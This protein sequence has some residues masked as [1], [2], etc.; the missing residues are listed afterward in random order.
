MTRKEPQD[1]L[2]QARG[3]PS[4]LYRPPKPGPCDDLAAFTRNIPLDDGRLALPAEL[5]DALRLWSLSRPQEGFTSRPELRGHVR[6]GLL[7]A[8]RLA[9]RLGPSWPVRFWDERHRTAKWVCWSCDRL[10]RERDSHAAP[11][12]PGDLTVEGEYGFGPLRAAGF[13]DFFPD[14]PAA[15]LDLSEELVADLHAWAAANDTTLDLYLRD[16]EEGRYDDT[17]QRLFRE[18]QELAR[19]VARETGPA[20]KVTYRGLANGGLSTMTCRTWQGEVEL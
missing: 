15:G 5:A 17:W 7:N 13:G 19:R 9:V 18:G 3:E 2:V 12:Y 1:L 8:R 16:R 14:D 11:A 6:R 20:R 4:P 10:H